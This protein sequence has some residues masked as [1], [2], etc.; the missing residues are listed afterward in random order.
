[1]F[2]MAACMLLAREHQLLVPTYRREKVIPKQS[3]RGPGGSNPNFSL[4][5]RAS[6]HNTEDPLC[7]GPGSPGP[8][9]PEPTPSSTPRALRGDPAE[10]G[11]GAWVGIRGPGNCARDLEREK[12]VPSSPTLGGGGEAGEGQTV[13]LGSQKC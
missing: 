8:M 3:L 11:R 2:T 4:P 1:M 5:A 9:A 12:V 10:V 6:L 7:P 13:P